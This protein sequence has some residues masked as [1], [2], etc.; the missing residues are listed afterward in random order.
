MVS[1]PDD[2]SGYWL[3]EMY[4]EHLPEDL[5]FDEGLIK[6][7]IQFCQPGNALDLGC[8]AGY[9]VR[10]LRENGVD[11]WGAEPSDLTN[12]FKAPGYQ[13]YQDISQPF[14]L[15]R[16][17]D[18]IIC[19]EVVEHIPKELENTVFDNIVKHVGKYLVFSGATPGQG[20]SGHINEE[21]ESYWFTHLTRRG[22]RLV[23]D[24]SIDAR[25][26]STLSWY[27]NNI[28][29]W[30]RVADLPTEEIAAPDYMEKITERDRQILNG[31]VTHQR[32]VSQANAQIEALRTE[33]NTKRGHI[34]W[35][36]SKFSQ[37]Q[38]ELAGSQSQ[39]AQAQSEL[40]QIH[41]QHSQLQGVLA[42]TQSQFLQTQAEIQALQQSLQQRQSNS[43]TRIKELKERLQEKRQQL[44]QKRSE[45]EGYQ[46]QLAAMEASKF[47]KLRQGWFK[48]K[49]SLGIPI[50]E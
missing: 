38:S 14:D 26:A 9:F 24:A 4:A 3:A 29:I 17:Y 11:A 30:E 21:P 41:S 20:G 12:V 23:L 18:L 27:Q 39:L 37:A 19:T 10:W 25:L 35:F 31:Q 15:E 5:A 32:F 1:S 7:V 8:G 22:L 34:E 46:N 6:A 36:Q 16:T 47:W 48:V 50:D 42:H 43:Q 44:D 49:R 28:A 33:L 13:I 40:S 45:I 2:L